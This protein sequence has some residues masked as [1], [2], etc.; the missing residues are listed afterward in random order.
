MQSFTRVA[1][2]PFARIYLSVY[3]SK[4]SALS[5]QTGRRYKATEITRGAVGRADTNQIYYPR[6]RSRWAGGG[7]K[8]RWRA[9]GKRERY[10]EASGP[11]L[12]DPLEETWEDG[13]TEGGERGRRRRFDSKKIHT[14]S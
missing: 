12:F 3:E 7:K 6:V 4:C 11:A 13:R 10:R 2:R 5:S 1:V 14:H 9:A 8:G